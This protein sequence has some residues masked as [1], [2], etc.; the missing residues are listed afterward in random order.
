IAAG[1][2]NPVT[3]TV[4]GGTNTPALTSIAPAT[5]VVGTS[6]A[7]TIAGSNLTG[8]TLNLPAGITPSAAP[9]VTATQITTTFVIAANA[10]TGPQSISVTTAGGTSNAAT[11]TVTAAAPS[12]ASIAPS[13]G[14]VGTSVA[15]TLTGA[16]LTGATLNL[17]AGITLSGAPAVT[18]T[19][20]TATLVI[21][22]NAATGAQSISATTA[23]GT[24]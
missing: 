5:G 11:F 9:A 23:A 24:S 1:T 3:F 21:A 6:V 18:A 4:I 22:A 12:L 19:Q 2:S 15:V 20:I 14:A 16:N 17:P 8:A 10:A 7:V 13:T